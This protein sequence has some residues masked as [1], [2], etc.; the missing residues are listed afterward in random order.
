MDE[1]LHYYILEGLSLLMV[2][3]RVC[4]RL[5]NVMRMG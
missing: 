4:S 1:N 5:S 3:R 2:Y